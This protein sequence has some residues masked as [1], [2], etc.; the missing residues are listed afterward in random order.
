MQFPLR[1]VGDAISISTVIGT[2]VGALPH[3]AA[4]LTVVWCVIRIYNEVLEAKI[5]RKRLL[6]E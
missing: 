6:D 3:I 4:V 1:P 5:K 2:L